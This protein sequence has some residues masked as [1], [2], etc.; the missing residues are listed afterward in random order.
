MNEK[1]GRMKGREKETPLTNVR[2]GRSRSNS[3]HNS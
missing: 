2:E 1:V 3:F